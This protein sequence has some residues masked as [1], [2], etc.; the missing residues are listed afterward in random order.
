MA[1]QAIETIKSWFRTG[2]YP[3]EAQFWDWMD[4]YFHKDDG[5]ITIDGTDWDNPIT[6][7]LWLADGQGIY[8]L[9]NINIG[10]AHGISILNDLENGIYISAYGLNLVAGGDSLIY[11]NA[12]DNKAYYNGY[13]LATKND[14]AN[15]DLSGYVKKLTNISYGQT[16]IDTSSGY[17]VT[18]GTMYGTSVIRQTGGSIDMEV[19]YGAFLNG[20]E[21]ATVDNVLQLAGNTPNTSVTGHIYMKSP[22]SATDQSDIGIAQNGWL[23]IGGVNTASESNFIFFRY[24]PQAKEVRICS[25]EGDINLETRSGGKA[26]FNNVQLATLNDLANLDLDGYVRN[27]A[28]NPAS[29]LVI[30]SPGNGNTLISASNARVDYNGYAGKSLI[31]NTSSALIFSDYNGNQLIDSRSTATYMYN[32]YASY[33]FLNFG[34]SDTRIGNPHKLNSIALRMDASSIEYKSLSGLDVIKSTPDYVAFYAHN[35]R[36][37]IGTRE[38]VTRI[39]NPH[40]G[41]AIIYMD[42]T[43]GQIYN[44]VNENNFV[45][46]YVNETHIISPHTGNDFITMGATGNEILGFTGNNLLISNTSYM[47]LCG[48]DGSEMIRSDSTSMDMLNPLNGYPFFELGR[49][50]ANIYNPQNGESFMYISNSRMEIWNTYLPNEFIVF[51]NIGMQMQLPDVTTGVKIPILDGGD[52]LGA[53]SIANLKTLLGI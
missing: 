28:A 48:Y 8:S 16:I 24:G 21:I 13:E 11:V 50:S 45:D 5:V 32:P 18:V 49:T 10:A 3:T 51:D 27:Y 38:S 6:G 23:S 9:G 44:P 2:K 19:S 42:D 39:Y 41:N 31:T 46:F 36:T 37:L 26:Y 7:P 22:V 40:T 14:I 4:S 15:I 29:E 12:S 17:E 30:T 43:I 33:Y 52:Y 53:I 35:G 20:S 47:S 25:V 34:S 1:V